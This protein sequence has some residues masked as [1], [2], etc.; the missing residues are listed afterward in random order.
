VAGPWRAEREPK[1]KPNSGTD[2][3]TWRDPFADISGIFRRILQRWGA[4]VR[5]ADLPDLTF[6]QLRF[7]AEEEV[8]T[9]PATGAQ[10]RHFATNDEFQE[11]LAQGG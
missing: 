2:E 11:F 8:T 1:K 3:D 9:D 10:I 5:F 7:L 6:A 4:R